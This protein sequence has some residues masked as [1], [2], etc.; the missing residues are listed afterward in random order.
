MRSALIGLVII[1]C[2]FIGKAVAQTLQGSDTAKLIPVLDLLMQTDE[3]VA[4]GQCNDGI[5]NDGDGLTDWQYDLGCWGPGDSS[6]RAAS[7]SQENG[8]T[9]FDLR[10]DSIVVY[11]SSSQGN[12][13]NDGLSPQT[14][15]ATPERGLAIT[16]G[17]SAD[18]MLLR[19]GDVWR[20]TTLNMRFHQGGRSASEK[21][22]I[23]SYGPSTRRPRLEV[24]N[25]LINDNGREISNLAVMGLEIVSYRKEPNTPLYDGSTGGGFRFVGNIRSQNILLEDNYLKYGELVVQSVDNIEI[26][27]NVIYRSYHAGTCAFNSDGSRNTHGN[28]GFRPSGMFMGS[29]TNTALLEGNVWDENGWN[30]DIP[31]GPNGACA[32]IYNHNVYLANVKNVTVRNDL[33]LRASS[34]GLKVSGTVSGGV[35]GLT[36]RDSLFAEGEIGIA[37]GGNGAMANTHN[38]STI[39]NNVFTDINRSRPTTREFTWGITVENNNNTL[40]ENNWFVNPPV[41]DRNAFAFGLSRDFNTGVVI[42]NNLAHGYNRALRVSEASG[43]GSVSITGN[44][45]HTDSGATGPLVYHRGDFSKTTYSGNLYYSNYT[46]SNP[47]SDGWFD[48]GYPFSDIAEWRTESGES[49]AQTS[50]FAAPDVGRNID[51]YASHLGIGSTLADF[52]REA[53]KQSRFNYRPQYEAQAVN[54]YIKEGYTP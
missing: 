32:T 3:P 51:A 7:R 20:D 25:H 29:N 40:Y 4:Q 8:W 19:R 27:R 30:P 41:S 44:R 48:T 50:S 54:A 42:R 22:I 1:Y 18:V 46:S 33:F 9:T 35:D 2:V 12:D 31:V 13:A 14:A 21:F 6:E 16:R 15:V 24:S 52:A 23:S 47:N 36:V 28:P 45:F 43:W 34:I 49:N 10:P 37:M 11:V 17:Q 39:A 26:R 5:D 53:R 38:N